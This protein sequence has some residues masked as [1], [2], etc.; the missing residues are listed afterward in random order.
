MMAKFMQDNGVDIATSNWGNY[1][2]IAL[3]NLRGYYT[4]VDA[5]NSATLR[6]KTN[7]FKSIS[8]I[9]GTN[10]GINS[11]VLLTTG[12][13]EQVKKQNLYDVAGNLWEWTMEAA[14]ADNLD[15]NMNVNYNTYMLRGGGF[16]NAHA[17]SP[18]VYRGYYYAPGTSTNNGFRATLYIK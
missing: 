7:G 18:A 2:D 3:T 9:T 15:Y 1:D 10:A 6:G 11:W 17:S 4:A 13:T 8:E 5:T 14:Y 12:S 16:N